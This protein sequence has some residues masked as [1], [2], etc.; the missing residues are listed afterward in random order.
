MKKKVFNREEQQ[1]QLINSGSYI[2]DKLKELDV[3]ADE[4]IKFAI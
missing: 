2:E 3:I 4:I 1:F